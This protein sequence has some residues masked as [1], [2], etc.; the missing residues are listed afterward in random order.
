MRWFIASILFLY[1]SVSNAQSPVDIKFTNYTRAN[2]LPEEHVNNIIQDSRGFLWIGSRE[3]L[4]RFDGLHFKSWYA[5]PADSTRF[6]SNNIS[7]T[8]EY[9]PGYILFLSGDKLW[10]LNIRNSLFSIL[11][12][13]RN[14]DNLTGLQKIGSNRWCIADA[15]SVYVTD[16]EIRIL[17]TIPLRKY[18]PSMVAA[19]IFPLRYPFALLYAAGSSNIYLLNENTRQVTPFNI[20]VSFLDSRAKFYI[21]LTFD[22]SRN[23]LYLSAYLN[24]VYS[25]DIRFGAQPAINLNT[26]ALIK[27]GAIRKLILLA[28]N[29]ILMGGENGLYITDESGTASFN[30]FSN[31]DR[32]M[33][34]GVIVHILKTKDNTFWLSTPNGISRFSLNKP[35]IG[36]WRNELNLTKNDEIKSILKANDGQFYFLSQNKSL[37]HLNTQIGTIRRLDSSITYSW[38]AEISEDD[39]IVTGGGKRIAQ[40]NTRS[41]TINYPSFLNKFYTANTDLV[42][43]VLKAKNGDTWY[44]CNGGG[45]LVLHPAG[46]EQYIQYHRDMKPSP[47]S[48]SYVHTAT[49][50]KHGNIWWASNKNA[51]LLK[52]DAARKGFEEFD[53][54]RLILEQKAKTGITR[55]YADKSGNLWIALDVAGLMRYNPDTRSGKYYDINSGLPGDAVYTMCSDDKSRLWFGTRKGLCCYLPDKDRII[56]FSSADGF[57]EDD[58]EG[59][60]IFFDE[61]EKKL[62]ISAKQSISYFNPDSLLKQSISVQQPLFIDEMQVNGSVYYFNDEDNIHLATKENNIEFSFTSPDFNRNAQLIFQYRLKGAGDEWIDIGD[63]RSVAFTGLPHGHYTFSVRC[64]YKGTENWTETSQPFSFTIKT[65]LVKRLWFRLLMIVFAFGLVAFFFRN[66]YQRK[67]ERQRAAA[68]KIQAVEKERTRIATDMHDDFGASLSRIKFISEKMQLNEAE[69]EGLKK[70]LGKISEYSDEMAEKMNEIVWALNQRYDSCEDLVS[71]CRSYASEYFQDKSILFSFTAGNI[72]DI[73][74][75]GEV[76]RNI[77]LV[78]KEALNNIVKHA[79]ATEASVNFSFGNGITVT[80]A[81]NGKGFEPKNVRPFANGLENMKKRIIDINGQLNISSKNG[82]SIIFTVPI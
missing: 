39:I 15:D 17:Y 70:D 32:P 53:I 63:K 3:G 76:R 7:V 73:K 50:D 21:P 60:G 27:E 81:D 82:T 74:I 35:L 2:G 25:A 54:D 22:S 1:F 55:L 24:G 48:H 28:G 69:N 16:E 29:I 23:R 10:K 20:D 68:E 11:P 51:K 56:T 26:T 47:F 61:A 9:K 41:H 59:Y 6:S 38:S 71:F 72:P 46:T 57:P 52:W 67:L 4:I 34:S 36:Y 66:Y 44:S 75:Q 8:A 79:A 40:Y 80:I 77:F 45:G 13:F 49:E 33:L 30:A 19:G 64:K 5:N 62:Y 37:F 43:L 31:S 58:F 18:Y 14:K 65:P 12:D 42:T 78:I